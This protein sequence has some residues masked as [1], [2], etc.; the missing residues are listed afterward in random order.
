MVNFIL[1]L[2]LST[3]STRKRFNHSDQA[4]AKAGQEN[5]PLDW[6]AAGSEW[7]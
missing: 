6:I 1:H 7:L 4:R 2:S 3:S 5:L